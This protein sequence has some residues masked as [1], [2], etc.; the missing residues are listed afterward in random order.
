MRPKQYTVNDVFENAYVG[1]EIPFRSSLN[2]NVLVKK[3]SDALRKS[4]TLTTEKAD[5]TTSNAPLLLKEW[6]GDKP[7]YVLKHSLVAF[8][9]LKQGLYSVLNVLNETAE[10]SV[11]MPLK[12]FLY[13]DHNRL[14]TLDTISNMNVS[15][16]I[17]H[18]DESYLYER[19][20]D[21]KSSPES[22]SVK[23]FYP[24]NFYVNISESLGGIDKSFGYP[25]EPYFG[26]DFSEQPKGILGFNYI[27]GV[28]TEKIKEVFEAIDYYII[29]TYQVLNERGHTLSE[30][31]SYER[32]FEGY[33]KARKAYYSYDAFLKEFEEIRVYVDLDNRYEK[34]KTLWPHLRETLMPIVFSGKLRKGRFN[35][36]S[37]LGSYQLKDARLSETRISNLQ[38]INCEL[39]GLF[40][41][42]TF[43]KCNIKD[44]RLIGSTLVSGNKVN[45]SVGDRIRADRNNSIKESF[46]NNE[47]EVINCPVE[48]SIIRNAV[49]GK[50]SKIDE[51]TV[52]IHRP[53]KRFTETTGMEEVKEIRNHEWIKS[54]RK[55][56]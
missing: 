6:E 27:V 32:I 35:W 19:F 15:K 47:D 3:L 41:D 22:F 23:N 2:E 20:P 17:L 36:D 46:I 7:G 13:F 56:D 24:Q 42:C 9:P 18:I 12:T 4:V 10:E 55:E 50:K 45:R 38:L 31:S 14:Q 40:E 44:S 8:K 52:V 1:F 34:I 16:M 28:Y 43:W 37:E 29:T 26:I 30:R 53:E 33:N 48:S 39:D 25:K 5:E 49:M 11:L 51:D 21:A 54:L